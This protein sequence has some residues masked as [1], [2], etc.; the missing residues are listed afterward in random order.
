MKEMKKKSLKK[1]HVK[2]QNKYLYLYVVQGNYGYGWED[3]T[4]S[5]SWREARDD[6]KAY[7]Q[8]D[9]HPHRIIERRELNP[10]YRGGRR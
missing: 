6:L 4:Q 3:L 2:K 1:T 8:N 10:K 5:E 9:P 7:R